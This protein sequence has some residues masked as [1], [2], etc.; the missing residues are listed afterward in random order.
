MT[1]CSWWPSPADS[2][3][4]GGR[5]KDR[6]KGRGIITERCP[7]TWPQNIPG[8]QSRAEQSR[9]AN[10]LAAHEGHGRHGRVRARPRPWARVNHKLTA[11]FPSRRSC[12]GLEKGVRPVS[13]PL[14]TAAILALRLHLRPRCAPAPAIPIPRRLYPFWC[15]SSTLSPTWGSSPGIPKPATVTSLPLPVSVPVFPRFHSS[16][17][18]GGCRNGQRHLACDKS[19]WRMT[20]C[21]AAIEATPRLVT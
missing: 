15:S 14:S 20:K 21:A 1:A 11:C 18:E 13:H 8:W 9:A 19:D 16:S 5:E 10:V 17:L 6:K 7:K 4:D 3:G 12:Q 2:G